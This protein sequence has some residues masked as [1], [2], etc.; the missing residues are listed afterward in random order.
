MHFGREY[1]AIQ[2]EGLEVFGNDLVQLALDP[3][4][5]Q[6]AVEVK[7]NRLAE[8]FNVRAIPCFS[9]PCEQRPY[10]LDEDATA[11]L[12]QLLQGSQTSCFAT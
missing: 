11:M 10:H 2:K 9:N 1:E 3:D 7:K 5:V 12:R 4:I 6:Q 8:A